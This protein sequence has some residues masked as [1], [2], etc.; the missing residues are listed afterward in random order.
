MRVWPERNVQNAEVY[1][2]ARRQPALPREPQAS[3]SSSVTFPPQRKGKKGL[4]TAGTTAV[5]FLIY[6]KVIL[7]LRWLILGKTGVRPW[8]TKSI[9][10]LLVVKRP[11]TKITVVLHSVHYVVSSFTR[12]FSSNHPSCHKELGKLNKG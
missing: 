11:R 3:R 4:S 10:S 12:Y 7:F 8:V 2:P 9:V 5:A 6:D 1:Y